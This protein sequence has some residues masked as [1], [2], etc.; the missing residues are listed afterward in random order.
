MSWSCVG[1]ARLRGCVRWNLRSPSSRKP[2]AV[3]STAPRARNWRFEQ[4]LVMDRSSA[5]ALALYTAHEHAVKRLDDRGVQRI[6]SVDIAGFQ[7]FLFQVD[8]VAGVDHFPTVLLAG[9][10]R[11]Q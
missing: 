11:P 3:G 2:R 5:L 10:L 9:P 8:R 4:T 6:V 7:H 1:T